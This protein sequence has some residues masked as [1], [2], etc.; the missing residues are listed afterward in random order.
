MGCTEAEVKEDNRNLKFTMFNP[1]PGST[2]LGNQRRDINND[3]TQ[4]DFIDDYLDSFLSQNDLPKEHFSI[5]A[6]FNSQFENP[7]VLIVIE[8]NPEIA[9]ENCL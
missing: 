1:P 8:F 7:R 5:L 4:Q 2:S 3:C 9:F 6:E